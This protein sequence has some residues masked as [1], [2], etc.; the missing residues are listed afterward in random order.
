NELFNLKSEIQGYYEEINYLRSRK[1]NIPRENLILRE[2][3]IRDLKLK[4]EDLPFIGEL[5]EVREEEKSWKGA[6]E[7]VLRHFALNL[8]VDGENYA[9]LNAYVNQT[10]LGRRISYYPVTSIGRCVGNLDASYLPA[11]VEVKG[12][13]PLFADWVRFNLN[14]NYNYK[15]CEDEEEF[16]RECPAVTKN[17][18]VKHRNKR[19]EKDD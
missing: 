5:I 14:N 3:I 9:R 4:E 2:K 16:N 12:D 18:L 11:K 17:G 15:C 7:R 1:S 13:N 19:H 6:I 10:H 8:L